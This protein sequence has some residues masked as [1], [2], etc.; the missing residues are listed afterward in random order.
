MKTFLNV[1]EFNSKLFTRVTRKNS[2][3][4]VSI[5]CNEHDCKVETGTGMKIIF[6]LAWRGGGGKWEATADMGASMGI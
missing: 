5:K 2:L 4:I 3:V 1:K 6:I